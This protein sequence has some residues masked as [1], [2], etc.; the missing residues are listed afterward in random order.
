M[1]A[2]ARVESKKYVVQTIAKHHCLQQVSRRFSII[3][4]VREIVY[5][6][7]VPKGDNRHNA[8]CFRLYEGCNYP[9]ITFL[10]LGDLV[11]C[12]YCSFQGA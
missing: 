2:S 8:L 9:L 7:A 1:Y 10:A 3:K 4:H 6:G 5:K 12:L 11:H